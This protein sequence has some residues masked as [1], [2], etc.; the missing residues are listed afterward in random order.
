MKPRYDVN[1]IG[2]FFDLGIVIK[3]LKRYNKEL[4]YYEEMRHE[5]NKISEK[6]GEKVRAG[7][8]ITEL[9]AR[10]VG[11]KEAYELY[12]KGVEETK[13]LL[14]ENTCRLAEIPYRFVKEYL[15]GKL[16]DHKSAITVDLAE[17]ELKYVRKILVECEK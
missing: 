8:D 3:I 5:R 11:L 15:P 16:W 9:K 2:N 12:E 13:R 4:A 7:E 14:L 10:A 17:E 6:I 1:D